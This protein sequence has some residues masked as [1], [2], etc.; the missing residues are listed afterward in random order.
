M[1]VGK[2][3]RSDH[4]RPRGRSEEECYPSCA[5]PRSEGVVAIKSNVSNHS[6]DEDKY[7]EGTGQRES[8]I[9]LKVK[10]LP[11]H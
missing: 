2:E 1:L 8:M 10:L 6:M 3:V 5:K 9:Y 11:P 7:Q 4:D